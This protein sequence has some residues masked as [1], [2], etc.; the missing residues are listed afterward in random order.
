MSVRKAIVIDGSYGE[1]GGQIVR[2][3]L[4]LSMIT[5]CPFRLINVRANRS[6]PGLRPQHLTAVRASARVCGARVDG[7]EL[8]A[9]E[10]HFTPGPVHGGEYQFHIG[11]AGATTLV[12]ETLLPPLARAERD[13]RLMITGGTHVPW[14]PPFHYLEQVF[15]PSLDQLGFRCECSIGRW[16]WY[17]KGGGEITALMKS[18]GPHAVVYLHHPFELERIT[19]ISASSRL[20]EHVRVRQR[21]QVRSRLQK[22]GLQADIALMDVPALSPGSFVFL[23]AHG[24]GAVAGFSSLGAR[25]KPAER[26]AD[27]AVDELLRFLDSRSALD[28]Y[29]AD[30]ILIYLAMIPGTHRI[31]T[32]AVTQH[33]LTNA[34]VTEQFLPVRFEVVGALHEPGLVVKRDRQ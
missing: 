1:G 10:F 21:Q 15:L 9:R 25:G 20:P 26:V 34:W 12:L 28:P 5:G 18:A 8:G 32:S 23:C 6:K 13:T 33:L 7:A 27:E 31:A 24:K 3:S 11:T 29:L 17:P 2:T 30:Q 4:S 22:A 16:G 14:S 19:A